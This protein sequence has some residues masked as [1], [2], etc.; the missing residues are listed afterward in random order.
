MRTARSL[1]DKDVEEKEA[2]A[3]QNILSARERCV[4]HPVFSKHLG[5]DR[6][7]FGFL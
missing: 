1:L 3:E 4:L 6:K 5:V 2:T 7:H